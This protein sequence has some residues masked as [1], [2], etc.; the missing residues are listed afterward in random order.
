MGATLYYL[1]YGMEVSMYL[2][3]ETPSLRVLINVEPEELER[4][5]LRFK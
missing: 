3:V 2:E 5:K 4:E 1:V